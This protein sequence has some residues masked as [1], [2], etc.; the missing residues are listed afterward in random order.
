ME[1]IR[2]VHD[3]ACRSQSSF[4]NFVDSDTRSARDSSALRVDFSRNF[5]PSAYRRTTHD[6]ARRRF[7]FSIYFYRKVS[8]RRERQEAKQP[9]TERERERESRSDDAIGRNNDALER[10]TQNACCAAFFL[11]LCFANYEITRRERRDS[12]VARRLSSFLS[13]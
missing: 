4:E 9:S 5:S 8:R 11:H 10:R 1:S 12:S 3:D 7:P 13:L 2:R 6:C